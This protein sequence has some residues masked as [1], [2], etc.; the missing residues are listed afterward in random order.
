MK[1]SVYQKVRK[2]EPGLYGSVLFPIMFAFILTFIGSRIVSMYAPGFHLLQ[3]EDGIRV[4]HYTYG[5]FILAVSG[6]LALV[7]NG[8]RA[9]FLIA[10]LHGFGL[11][12]A[13]DE[14]GMWLKLEDNDIAR[15]SYD[16]FNIIVGLSLLILTFKPGLR[17]IKSIFFGNSETPQ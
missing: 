5:I 2:N 13:F 7:L 10:L 11:G 4:H 17:R 12:L 1:K 6:Y 16:G 14:L 3:I 8:P 15:W 9:T